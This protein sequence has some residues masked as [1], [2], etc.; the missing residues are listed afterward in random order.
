LGPAV[1]LAQSSGAVLLLMRVPVAVQAA[2]PGDS[3][4]APPNSKQSLAY[5]ENQAR[6]YLALLRDSLSRAGLQIRI[7]VPRGQPAEVILGV[8]AG[9]Q[10]DLIVMSSHGYSGVTRWL[11]GSVA[12]KVLQGTACPVLVVRSADR[13]RRMLI[14]LDGSDFSEKALAPALEVAQGL[15]LHLTLFR[16]VPSIERSQ[17]E[18]LEEVEHGLGIRI[19]EQL[20]DDA[21]DYLRGK[22]A[23][24][25]RPGVQINPVVD[26]EPA[27]PTILE[28]A[29]SDSIDLIAMATHGFSALP[30]LNRRGSVTEKVLHGA[31]HSML[32]IPPVA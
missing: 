12:E 5:S 30:G 18:M 11:A 7:V 26:Y 32:V 25:R 6:E 8:A 27:A 17:F 1:A 22:V 20:R 23:A 10:A 28:C 4:Y 24:C 16:A 3:G 14:P 19:Q 21:V 31:N 9:E 2:I 29:E 13:P 15:G